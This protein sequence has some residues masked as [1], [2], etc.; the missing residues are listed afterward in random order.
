M[1]INKES[2]LI[3]SILV[4]C[5]RCQDEADFPVLEEMGF[6]INEVEALLALSSTD[7]LR[8]AATKSHFLKISLDREI[9]WRMIHYIQAENE[10]ESLT[11]ELLKNEA[12]LPLMYALT[13]MGSKAYT[14]R[15]Q[16]FGLDKMKPGRPAIPS[17][18]VTD[19][20]WKELK[21]VVEKS[22]LFGAKEFLKIYYRLNEEIPLRVIW[23]LFHEWEQSGSLKIHRTHKPETKVL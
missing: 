2:E 14:V 23:Y 13:G 7:K 3:H 16:Q 20:V 15:R 1:S 21:R 6:G 10:K 17:D 11:D 22:E 4:Y 19:A 8:L 12:P 5:Q 18:E 9:F